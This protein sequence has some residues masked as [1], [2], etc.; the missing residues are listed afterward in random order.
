MA[1]PALE[2]FVLVGGTALSL[3]IGH[4]I[5]IALDLYNNKDFD[6]E[7]LNR[8]LQSSYH[9]LPDFIEQNTLKGSID[10]MALDLIAHKYKYVDHLSNIEGVRLA[11]FKDIAAMKLNAIINNGT[12]A[13][14]FVDIAFLGESLSFNQMTHS[15]ESKYETN[16]VMA[17]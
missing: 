13:K 3:R 5:S 12:K 15:F 9:F 4:R 11:S 17:T 1:D 7:K 6:Q 14:D 8:H 2:N 16:A 10:G